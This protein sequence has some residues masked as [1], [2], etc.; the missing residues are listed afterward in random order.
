MFQKTNYALFNNIST[1]KHA[2]GL[3]DVGVP[4]GNR[5]FP[6]TLDP[7]SRSKNFAPTVISMRN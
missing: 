3:A 6:I 2:S 5:N 4:H 1:M 7:G